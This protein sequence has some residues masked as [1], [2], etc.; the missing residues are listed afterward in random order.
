MVKIYQYAMRE[1]QSLNEQNKLALCG[2]RVN[3]CRS[4]GRTVK[5]WRAALVN[6]HIDDDYANRQ[7][8]WGLPG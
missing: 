8:R 2:E 6:I 1:L 4:S 5:D 7:A 3:A